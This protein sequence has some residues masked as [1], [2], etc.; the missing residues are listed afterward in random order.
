MNARSSDGKV[1]DIGEFGIA[2]I[3]LRAPVKFD[4]PLGGASVS[5]REIADEIRLYS[6]YFTG[7]SEFPVSI[8]FGYHKAVGWRGCRDSKSGIDGRIDGEGGGKRR[9]F[10]VAVDTSSH[11]HIGNDTGGG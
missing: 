5:F 1:G 9:W 6:E 10:E 8:P 11:L 7:E 4:Y 3:R 2:T